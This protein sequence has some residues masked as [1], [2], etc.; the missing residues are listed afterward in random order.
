MFLLS[1]RFKLTAILSVVLCALVC[2]F[3][4]HY[5]N[6]Q[7]HLKEALEANAQQ[8]VQIQE[9][10]AAQDLIQ[11]DINKGN[12]L[13][14]LVNSQMVQAQRSVDDMRAKFEAHPDPTTGQTTTLGQQAVEKTDTVERAINRG[15]A[16]QLRCFELVSGTPPT[17][18]EKAGKKPNSFCPELL[19]QP[20]TQSTQVHK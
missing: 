10:K 16:D 3:W 20:V 14:Q 6:T 8:Q 19:M 18:E 17:D 4:I 1:T 2:G 5:K 13:R 7:Q 9:Q 12:Q 15:T 11:K